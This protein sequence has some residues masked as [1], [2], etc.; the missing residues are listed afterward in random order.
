MS[1]EKGTSVEQVVKK[2]IDWKMQT[3]YAGIYAVIFY[4]V[5]LK[6]DGERMLIH[7]DKNNIDQHV[8]IFSKSRRDST[9]DREQAHQI[10]LQAV[11]YVGS[12]IDSC[13]LEAE[14]VSVNSLGQI[15]GALNHS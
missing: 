4:E 7:Y 1:S 10:I 12:N 2:M 11:S 9:M 13:I 15:E 6:Y 14:L 8:K 5:E 3:I